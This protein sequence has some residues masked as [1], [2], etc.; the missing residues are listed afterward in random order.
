MLLK[1]FAILIVLAFEA[2]CYQ[3][4]KSYAV[5]VG[6][7]VEKHA[8]AHHAELEELTAAD[9]CFPGMHRLVFA[10]NDDDH[11]YERATQTFAVKYLGGVD[12]KDDLVVRYKALC[13]QLTE[14]VDVSYVTPQVGDLVASLTPVQQ[15]LL[16]LTKRDFSA[17]ATNQT[18]QSGKK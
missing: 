15:P 18:T 5:V 4:L 12:S 7:K 2:R 16:Q 9:L 10:E 17:S 1:L 8:H 13:P 11:L 6:D 3:T 14:V